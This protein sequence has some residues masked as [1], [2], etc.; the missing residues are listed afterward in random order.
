MKI[1]KIG[2]CCLLL[3]IVPAGATKPVRILTDPG[4]YSTNQNVLTDID[5]IVISHEHTDHYHIDSVRAILNNNPK[6]K[7]ITNTAVSELLKK[8]SIEFS[9][10]G[11]EQVADLAGISIKGWGKK[12]AQIYKSVEDVENTGYIFADTFYYPGDAFTQP[13]QPIDILAL[14]VAGPWMKISEALEFALMVKPKKCFPVHDGNLR[15]Y[16]VAHRLPK[17]VLEEVGIT[18]VALE[19]GQLSEF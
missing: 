2:H 19:T 18:F 6:A 1:T 7:I 14:P 5:F 17:R 12:H 11:H 9:I 10:V 8:E 16:G 4:N 3:E 15:T 13:N